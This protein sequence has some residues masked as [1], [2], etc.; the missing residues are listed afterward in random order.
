MEIKKQDNY[1]FMALDV[2]EPKNLQKLK[3]S[4]IGNN[5]F[6]EI[7]TLGEKNGNCRFRNR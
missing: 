2:M 7:N 3:E 6:K 1:N 4:I 5:M